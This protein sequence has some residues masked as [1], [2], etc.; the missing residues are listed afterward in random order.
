[1]KNC[2]RAELNGDN[3]WTVKMIKGHKKIILILWTY[4]IIAL[5]QSLE[6]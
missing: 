1:M 2:E 3:D 6:F 4:N 5:P